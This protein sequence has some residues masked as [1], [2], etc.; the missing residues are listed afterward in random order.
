MMV[1][2]SSAV[3]ERVH[4]DRAGSRD[5]GRGRKDDPAAAEQE[6]A[7]SVEVVALG[8]FRNGALRRQRQAEMDDVADHLQPGPGI[9]VDAELDAAHPAR[10]QDLRQE[11]DHRAGD[12]DDEG[13]AGHALGG[14]VL[15]GEPRLAGARAVAKRERAWR[16]RSESVRAMILQDQCGRLKARTGLVGMG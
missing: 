4:G 9:D 16:D 10:Q 13:G 15:A 2:L 1:P 6:A 3:L 5:H 8:V 7:Q 14:A 12:A 11:D